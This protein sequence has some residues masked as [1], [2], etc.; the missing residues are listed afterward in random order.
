[1]AELDEPAGMKFNRRTAMLSSLAAAAAAHPLVGCAATEPPPSGATRLHVMGM[2]HSN[3][4]TSET[5]S[6]SVL[7]AAI[8]KAAPDIILTEIPPDRIEQAVTSFQTT[9]VIDEPRTEVFPEY[10]DALFPLSQEMGFRILGTAGWTRAIAD[11]RRTA[12]RRIQND[13]ARA[14]QWAEHRAAQGAYSRVLAGR[15][16]DPLFIHTAE[17]DQLVE[18]S[19]QPYQRYFDDDLGPGGWTQINRAHTDLINSALDMVT[20]QGL[21]ALVTFGSAHKYKIL[22]SIEGRSDIE[23]LDT[24]SLFV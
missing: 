1:M 19:R 7:K 9:G 16:D 6:L 13:S 21:T 12:L 23:L 10:T 20:G 18:T 15:G 11:N 17:F 14:D 24:R 2:I 8:R 4:R 3:H 5:Y 22:R